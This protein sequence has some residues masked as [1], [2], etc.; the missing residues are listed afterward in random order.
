MHD[1]KLTRLEMMHTKSKIKIAQRGLDLLKMKRAS[2]VLAF[3]KM[4]NEIKLLKVDLYGIIADAEDRIKIAEIYSGR[5]RLERIAIEHSRIG[6]SIEAENIMGVKI[7]NI[8]LDAKGRENVPYE[9]ISVPPPVHDAKESFERAF[10]MLIEIAEKENSLRKLLKEID[11]LNRRSNAIEN[12][13]IPRM[14]GIVEYIGQGLEDIERD[15]LV[16]LKFI[17]GKINAE[18]G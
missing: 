18:A 5:I 4:I 3:F 8:K 14:E 7:P 9:L 17:K 11:K 12:I 1:A 6:A 13:A 10:R 16:S 15:Q 2:L